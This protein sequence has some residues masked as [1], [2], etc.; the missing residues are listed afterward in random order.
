[1][2]NRAQTFAFE[3]ISLNT[4]VN[5][6][7]KPRND[8]IISADGK[9]RKAKMFESRIGSIKDELNSLKQRGSTG[10][11]TEIVGRKVA[12]AK[13]EVNISVEGCAN[14]S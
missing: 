8:A 5:G 1:M 10:C 4:Q 9:G 14:V 7:A 6:D 3:V 2:P 11:D 13:G 12:N